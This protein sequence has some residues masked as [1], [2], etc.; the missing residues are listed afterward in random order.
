MSNLDVTRQFRLFYEAVEQVRQATFHI[1]PSHSVESEKKEYLVN[2]EISP[3]PIDNLFNSLI[4]A[5][6]ERGKDF[7]TNGGDYGSRLFERVIYVFAAFADDM[8]L[9]SKWAG[10]D[11]WIRAPLEVKLFG[12]QSAGEEIFDDIDDGLSKYEFGRRDLA[13]IYLLALNMGFEGRFKGKASEGIITNYKSRLFELINDR[14]ATKSEARKSFLGSVYQYNQ[15]GGAPEMMSYL[16]PW[17]L[18]IGAIT[19]AYLL[20]AHFIWTHM[21]SVLNEQVISTIEQL[22]S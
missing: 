21:V 1:T 12:S 7:S 14:T 10:R 5:L 16:R 11:E 6:E 22:S 9:K 19:L 17:L 13:R 3:S 18:T 20:G 15:T 2:G 4:T 8:M